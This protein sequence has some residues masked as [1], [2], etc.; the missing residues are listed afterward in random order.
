MLFVS[1]LIG[2]LFVCLALVQFAAYSKSY[3]RQV[4]YSLN[5]KCQGVGTGSSCQLELDIPQ[6]LSPPLLFLYTLSGSYVNHRKY[7][8][9][10]SEPQLQGTAPTTQARPSIW[11]LPRRPAVLS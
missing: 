1:V 11:P 6:D 4:T 5:G 8:G 7:I 3:S 10:S 9:S 2:C